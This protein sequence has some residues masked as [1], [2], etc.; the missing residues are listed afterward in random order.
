MPTWLIIL[1]ASTSVSIILSL[2]AVVY[3]NVMNKIKKQAAELLA[4]DKRLAE[5][6]LIMTRLRE[7]NLQQLTELKLILEQKFTVMIETLGTVK[8]D[9]DDKY[10]TKEV[11][12]FLIQQIKER[13]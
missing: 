13:G 9:I 5:H 10:L 6:D 4:H 2:I 8:K 12:N 11:F 1:V 7:A 3:N